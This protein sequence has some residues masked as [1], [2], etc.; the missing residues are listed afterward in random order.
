MWVDFPANF[1]NH[2]C[3]FSFCD[4]HGE[5]HKWRTGALNIPNDTPLTPGVA[6]N[7]ADWIWLKDHATVRVQ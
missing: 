5:V 4:A 2:A 7:N 3:G 6:P 1:H